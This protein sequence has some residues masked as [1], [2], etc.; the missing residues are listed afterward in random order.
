MLKRSFVL[1]ALFAA[2]G[3]T[4]QDAGQSSSALDPAA[5]SAASATDAKIVAVANSTVVIKVPGMT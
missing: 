1:L 3:C 4:Q 5:D 2:V